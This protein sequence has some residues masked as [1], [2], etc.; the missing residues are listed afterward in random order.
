MRVGIALGGGGARG[1]AHV[2]ILEILDELGIRPHRIAGTSIGAVVGAV[3]AGGATAAEMRSAAEAITQTSMDRLREW[4]QNPQRPVHW[5][6]LLA[7]EWEATGLLSAE[8]FLSQLQEQFQLSTFDALSIPLSIVATD[9]WSR[10]EVVF[11][12]GDVLTAVRA[13]MA[14][15]GIFPP[16]LWNDKLLTDGGAVNPVPFDLLFADCDYTI[17]VDVMGR[18]SAEPDLAPNFLETM[19]GTFQ[20][21]ERVIIDQKL[22]SRRPD[23]YLAPDICG[24][25][26]LEFNKLDQIFAETEPVCAQLRA[27]LK[28]LVASAT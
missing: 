24:V 12:E 27:A 1:L 6:Q 21:M 4:F 15:P 7:P 20:I 9:Y 22:A 19:L 23:L 8:R 10:S 13:S 28:P 26:V 14:V 18:R 2:A 17:A 16:L 3:Y 25:K 5:L 11:T